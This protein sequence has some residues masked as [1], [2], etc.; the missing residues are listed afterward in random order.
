MAEHSWTR[1]GCVAAQGAPGSCSG[2]DGLAARPSAALCTCLCRAQL[3]KESAKTDFGN[4]CGLNVGQEPGPVNLRLALTSLEATDLLAALCL[5]GSRAGERLGRAGGCWG[6]CRARGAP[7]EAVP[8]NQQRDPWVTG[9]TRAVHG[10]RR[11][12]LG[13]GDPGGGFASDP[14]EACPSPAAPGGLGV[15]W[16]CGGVAKI[17]VA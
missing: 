4:E 6:C 7:V 1:V 16:R 11:R 13:K 5:P 9:R 17:P 15:A 14:T 10:A 12:N 8:E 2:T 3:G